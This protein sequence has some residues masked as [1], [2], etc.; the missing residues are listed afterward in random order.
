MNN[1]RH[2]ED[3]QLAYHL[4]LEAY[5]LLITA[6]RARGSQLTAKEE[7]VLLD[8][9]EILGISEQRHEA[10]FRRA[11]HDELLTDLATKIN[12]SDEWKDCTTP[13]QFPTISNQN[14]AYQD[15]VNSLSLLCKRHNSR[16]RSFATI[17]PAIENTITNSITEKPE[18][19]P[20]PLEVKQS[21]SVTEKPIEPP[22]RVKTP[23]KPSSSSTNIPN[24]VANSIIEHTTASLNRN[25]VPNPPTLVLACGS[26]YYVM[27]SA[28]L[29]PTLPQSTYSIDQSSKK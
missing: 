29:L 15:T 20:E 1:S 25:P 4:S 23:E 19:K 18:V 17:E 12:G 7:N 9:K 16:K 11:T 22:V 3:M 24:I 8:I 2:K 14:K 13:S 27:P 10:E 26:Q 6:L 21:V 28:L 5:S